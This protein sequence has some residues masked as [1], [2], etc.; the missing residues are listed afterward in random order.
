MNLVV[1]RTKIV[2]NSSCLSAGNAVSLS[3]C[4]SLKWAVYTFTVVT[5]GI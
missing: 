4:F 3:I 2:Y 5:Q 1:L